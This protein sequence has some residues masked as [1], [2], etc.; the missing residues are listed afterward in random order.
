MLRLDL[1][2][3]VG[4]A[5]LRFLPDV[6]TILPALLAGWPATAAMTPRTAAPL[7]YFAAKTLS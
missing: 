5:I 3:V 6:V 2:E 4:L 7:W 1:I